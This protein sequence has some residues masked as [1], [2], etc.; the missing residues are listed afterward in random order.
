MKLHQKDGIK[1]KSEVL[2]KM[3]RRYDS[4][5]TNMKMGREVEALDALTQG[6]SNLPSAVNADAEKYEV[7][8]EVDTIKA[9]I[10]E[11]LQT[12]YNLDEKRQQES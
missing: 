4:Y 8:E 1:A 5:Q 10:L 7:M 11:I 3:Q 2:L 12:N 9:Q 6:I